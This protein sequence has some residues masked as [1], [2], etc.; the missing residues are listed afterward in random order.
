MIHDIRIT[1][2]RFDKACHFRVVCSC[3]WG[4]RANPTTEADSSCQEMLRYA[5]NVEIWHKEH[6][7]EE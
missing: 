2:S 6:P 1:N 4:W 5:K 7:E 3:G